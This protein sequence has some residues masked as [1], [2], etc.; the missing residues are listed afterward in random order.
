MRNLVNSIKEFF[1]SKYENDF[2]TSIQGY[3]IRSAKDISAL[4]AEYHE[5][6]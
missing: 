1:S 2:Y 3:R 6:R 4:W 5:A